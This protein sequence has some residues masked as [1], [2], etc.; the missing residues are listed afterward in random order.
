MEAETNK[1][2]G[3]QWDSFCCPKLF[4]M[5]FSKKNTLLYT[6]SIYSSNFFQF[7]KDR[8]FSK[9]LLFLVAKRHS[10]ELLSIYAHSTSNLRFYS[11]F[12]KVLFFSKNFFLNKIRILARYQD[13][14]TISRN[15]TFSSA[16]YRKFLKFGHE[17]FN[18][19]KLIISH[20][21]WM[22]S[23][24]KKIRVEWMIFLPYLIMGGK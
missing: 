3:Y 4:K 12:S 14:G 21:S 6:C 22:A 19:F 16:F 23:K 18:F 9:K 24:L 13:F 7:L 1:T 11:E 20:K 17:N 5:P 15:L 2:P 10:S 8:F